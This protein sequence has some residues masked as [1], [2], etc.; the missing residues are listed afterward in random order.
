MVQ[1]STA[2][3]RSSNPAGP[4]HSWLAVGTSAG[5]VKLYD[6]AT[7]ELRWTA[8]HANEGYVTGLAVCLFPAPYLT[9]ACLGPISHSWLHV[10]AGL[11]VTT[12]SSQTGGIMADNLLNRTPC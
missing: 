12:M 6:S 1:K 4:S 11:C 2:E 5:A 9:S 7:G 10:A 8:A 3:A